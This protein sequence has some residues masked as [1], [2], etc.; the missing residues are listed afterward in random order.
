MDEGNGRQKRSPSSLLTQQTPKDIVS[1]WRAARLHP[2]ALQG[3]ACEPVGHRLCPPPPA[4]HRYDSSRWTSRSL[5]ART[6]DAC[7]S[8]R[9]E[10]CTVTKLYCFCTVTASENPGRRQGEREKGA[11]EAALVGV[12]HTDWPLARG[13]AGADGSLTAESPLSLTPS[14][15]TS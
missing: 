13:G 3:P 11:H 1:M 7:S 10:S 6:S 8:S 15:L 5:S 4:F 12:A 9:I 2:Q 14:D